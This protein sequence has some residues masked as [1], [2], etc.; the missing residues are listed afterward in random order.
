M[1]SMRPFH[2]VIYVALLITSF[3]CGQADP[4][5]EFIR[6]QDGTF[7]RLTDLVLDSG[8]FNRSGRSIEYMSPDSM[9]TLSLH[10]GNYERTITIWSRMA[11]YNARGV[12]YL[13]LIIYNVYQDDLAEALITDKPEQKDTIR[14]IIEGL[15][16]RTNK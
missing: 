5:P 15:I 2:S 9:N 12:S 10:V 13:P 16:V 11:G 14:P 8:E 4:H 6:L 7:D 3:S 1:K